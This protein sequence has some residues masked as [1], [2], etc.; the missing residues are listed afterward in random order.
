MTIFLP[1]IKR[2]AVHFRK[3]K[4]DR[5]ELPNF[6]AIV[7]LLEAI[8]IALP[9]HNSPV[10]KLR[11]LFPFPGLPHHD[12]KTFYI[13]FLLFSNAEVNQSIIN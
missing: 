13:I 6:S 8:P 10:H 1:D 7:P 5:R 9:T 2:N 3:Y 11:N 12:L 4:K